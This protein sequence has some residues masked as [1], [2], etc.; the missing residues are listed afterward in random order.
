M[1]LLIVFEK[2]GLG[3]AEKLARYYLKN[4]MEYRSL[5]PWKEPSV[6]STILFNGTTRL[7]NL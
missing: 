5:L 1:P 2:Y 3:G 6:E 7:T 4:Q